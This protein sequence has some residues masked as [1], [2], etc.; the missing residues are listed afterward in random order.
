MEKPLNYEHTFKI[1]ILNE[2]SNGVYARLLNFVLKKGIDTSDNKNFYANLLE[3]FS[4]MRNM[5]LFKMTNEELDNVRAY[6]ENMN[7]YIKG[8]TKEKSA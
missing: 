3:Q 5:N 1:E 4:E 2:F 6:W 7:N 8:I